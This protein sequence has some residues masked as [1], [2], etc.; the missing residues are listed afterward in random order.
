MGESGMRHRVLAVMAAILSLAAGAAQAETFTVKSFTCPLTG[1]PFTQD[2]GYSTFPLVTFPDGSYP[3]DEKIDT[4]IPVCPAD[5]LV[6]LPDFSPPL[7]E[8]QAMSDTLTYTRY[9]KAEL[10]RLPAL[11]AGPAY[12]ALKADGRYAQAHWLATQLGRPVFDRFTMLQRATWAA[13][14]PALR[15]KLV[16]RLVSEGPALIAAS[17][18]P[19]PYKR[20]LQLYI[21][22]GLRELGR[23]DEAITLLDAMDREAAAALAKDEVEDAEVSTGEMRTVIA[24]KDMDRFPVGLMPSK[25]ANAICNDDRDMPPPYTRTATTKAA[26]ATREAERKRSA[27]EDED[28]FA[29]LDRWRKDVDG[30]DKAC[31][32][33][34]EDKRSKGLQMGCESRQARRDETE[35]AEFVKDGGRAAA[36]CEA[37]REDEHEGVLLYACMDYGIVLEEEL[38]RALADDDLAWSIICPKGDNEGYSYPDRWHIASSGCRNARETRKNR[39]VEAMLADPAKI[40]ATCAMTPEEKMHGLLF[41]ACLE[42]NSRRRTETIE[43]LATKPA[44]FDQMCARYAKTNSAGN[45]VFIKED[46]Q[47]VCRRAWRLRENT[48]AKVEAEAKGLKCFGGGAYGP[49]RPRCV[50]PEQ[51]EKDMKPTPSPFLPVNNMDYFAEDSSLRL[52]A[53]ARAAAIIAKAKADKTFPKKRPGDRY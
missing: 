44:D 37:A 42:R 48:R 1:K 19:A 7:S 10:A 11:M 47:E 49:D 29:E 4:Q 6:I 22:N 14:D 21:V 39:A 30:L 31:A 23:F 33:T 35:A 3:G 17:D 13:V 40:D 53:R 18:R 15:R 20:Y 32:A 9:T 36:A 12:A 41:S 38:G 45:D 52:T 25:W 24:A 28:A 2:V 46:E 50:S 26:C 34:P 27:R 43:Q 16:E 5:G 51:F 8:V